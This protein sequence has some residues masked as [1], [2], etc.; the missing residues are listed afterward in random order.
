MNGVG[1]VTFSTAPVRRAARGAKFAFAHSTHTHV[2]R[3]AQMFVQI[4]IYMCIRDA[5]KEKLGLND[6][7]VHKIASSMVKL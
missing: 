6:E 2:R 4:L 7:I 5:E 1:F 3:V